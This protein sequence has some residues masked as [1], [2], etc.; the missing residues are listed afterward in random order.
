MLVPLA[1]LLVPAGSVFHLSDYAV[2]L[3]GK[4]M[5]Y[6]IARWRWT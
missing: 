1:N 5:C 4:I 6:A 2:Q 3:V